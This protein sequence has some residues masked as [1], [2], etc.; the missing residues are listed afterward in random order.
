ME[1]DVFPLRAPPGFAPKRPSCT[2]QGAAIDGA[3]LGWKNLDAMTLDEYF[4]EAA[5]PRRLFEAVAQ[6]IS[7][8]GKVR[9][10]VSKSQVAFRRRKNVAVVWMPGKY[11]KEP[12][13]PLVLTLSFA[14]KDSSPR[15][16]QVIQAST[17]SFTHH[18]E[19]YRVE[20][21]D[22]QVQAWLRSAWEAAA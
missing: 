21:I 22:T 12:V 2:A 1:R 17:N 19:L 14:E 20:D 8:F 6:E 4:N 15:W 13:A 16:K 9:V 10:G 11:L 5:L 18:L 7:R 3:T